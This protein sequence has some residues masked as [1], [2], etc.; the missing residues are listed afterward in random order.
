M[1]P[2]APIYTAD[3]CQAAYEL[4]WTLAVFWKAPPP[5]DASWLGKLREAT[6]ADSVRVLEHRIRGERVS[7]FL[8][9]T[10]PK[11]AP[12]DMVRSVKGRLQHLLR[13][14]L[15]KAF[16]RN[17]G[18]RS[19]GAVR[20]DVVRGYIEKQVSRYRMADARVQER[21]ESLKIGGDYSALTAPRTSGHA[22]FWYNLHLVLVS[23]NR[24]MEVRQQVLE[25]RSAMIV[26]VAA[27]KRHLIGS[28][29]IL[30]DHIHLTLGCHLIESPRDIVLSY[31]NNLAFGELMRPIYE[32]G[33]YTGTFGEYDL[34][35][36]WQ[37][38]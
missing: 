19:V 27:K 14:T 28:G 21:F 35:A 15:P 26:A 11:T 5:V 1:K 33:F 18:L 36:I 37:Q 6:E 32:F 16:Q 13:D 17:Y 25:R 10:Q 34:G 30:A 3:N 31:L 29:Q 4:D 2:V 22:Q 24:D 23:N 7:Q 20:S 8:L 12:A 9:S 38:Q